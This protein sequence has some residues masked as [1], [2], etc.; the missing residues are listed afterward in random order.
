MFS[1]I[2]KGIRKKLSDWRQGKEE[3]EALENVYKRS[4]A[5]MAEE[6]NYDG[7]KVMYA[8]RNAEEG[9]ARDLGLTSKEDGRYVLNKANNIGTALVE[10]ER[11][12]R[13]AEKAKNPLVEAY[14]L[15]NLLATGC[16]YGITAASTA[17]EAGFIDDEAFKSIK[18]GYEDIRTRSFTDYLK[19]LYSI[20]EPSTREKEEKEE[21]KPEEKEEQEKEKEIDFSGFS[22][23]LDK[24][25]KQKLVEEFA[26]EYREEEGVWKDKDNLETYTPVQEPLYAVLDK[27]G[28]LMINTETRAV[29]PSNE[30]GEDDKPIDDKPTI[31]DTKEGLKGYLETAKYPDTGE[32]IFGDVK[33]EDEYLTAKTWD[34]NGEEIKIRYD[35]EPGTYAIKMTGSGGEK[36]YPDRYL[37]GIKDIREQV[38]EQ[39]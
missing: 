10:A 21:E 20:T 15:D 19:E 30:V 27:K 34:E 17:K 33:Y 13:M 23:S 7:I 6:G 26:S 32:K 4:I 14:G 36:V 16:E 22:N 38:S 35:K 37:V 28:K 24:E 39:K 18:E 1:G 11:S 9:L 5:R 12:R 25:Q 2:R 29:Y 3:R 8:T 31:E